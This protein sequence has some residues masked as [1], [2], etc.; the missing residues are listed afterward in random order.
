ML[1]LLQ[2]GSSL[3]VFLWAEEEVCLVVDEGDVDVLVDVDGNRICDAGSGW[4]RARSEWR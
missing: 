3:V 1:P 2:V 4:Y